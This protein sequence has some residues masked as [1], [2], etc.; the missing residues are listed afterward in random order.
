MNY[1]HGPHP[2]PTFITTVR[3]YGQ[4]S[5]VDVSRRRAMC[6]ALLADDL[7]PGEVTCPRCVAALCRAPG[8]A[9]KLRS[10]GWGFGE[11]L[12]A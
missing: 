9:N 1:R 6:G 3:V 8:Y 7:A 2:K 4:G 12:G 5:D 10:E 11:A